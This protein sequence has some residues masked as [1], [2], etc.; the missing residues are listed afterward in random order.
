MARSL[1][2]ILGV[3]PGA[4]TETIRV[5]YRR[6]VKLHHPDTNGDDAAAGERFLAIQEAYE[7]LAD[8][9]KRADYDR[10]P[11]LATMDEQMLELRRQSLRRRRYR[12][13]RIYQI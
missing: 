13:M 3:A 10:A 1:Y 7:I 5:A 9:D 2:E 11:A 8:P 6:L 4:S 12:L